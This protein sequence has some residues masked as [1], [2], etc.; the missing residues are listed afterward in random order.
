MKTLLLSG[1]ALLLCSSMAFAAKDVATFKGGKVTADDYKRAVDALG[2]QSEM[3][4]SNAGLRTQYLDHIIDSSLMAIE[5]EK[6]S[7]QK[8]ETFK[9]MLE[10]AKRDLL[11]RLYLDAY[12]KEQTTDAKLKAYFEANKK[13]F[14][15]KEVRASHIL[16]KTEDKDK[17][18]KILK[19]AQKKGADFAELAKKHS[20]G[21]SAPRGGDLDF[22]GRGRMVPEFEK[23]AFST[24]KGKVYPK[25]VQ[26]QFGWHVIKVTDL[27]GGDTVKF[28]DKK[29]DVLRAV[30]RSAKDN[31]VESLR[32]KADV[33]I[34]EEQLKAIKL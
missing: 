7:L 33:K 3:L 5:A 2:P 17:A 24:E 34:N 4:K 11:A 25:L 19:E 12:V 9:A 15:D 30:E 20:T 31:L 22:F 6:R 27:R 18:E 32:K 13:Q 28:E 21:P 16:F 26:T 1:T 23:A 14:S 29:E 8:S 10:G